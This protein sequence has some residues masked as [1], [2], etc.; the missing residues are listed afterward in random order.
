MSRTATCPPRKGALDGEERWSFALRTSA[1]VGP[2]T[3]DYDPFITSE[4]AS[5]PL[6]LGPCVV[7]IWSRIP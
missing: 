2:L 3:V 6:T 5:T 7:Q 1:T 4:P